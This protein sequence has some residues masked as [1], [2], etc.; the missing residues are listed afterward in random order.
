MRDQAIAYFNQNAQPDNLYRKVTEVAAREAIPSEM[1][2]T[3][4]NGTIETVNTVPDDGQSYI[5]VRNIAVGT[6]NESYFMNASKF[7]DRYTHTGKRVSIDGVA[8]FIAAPKGKVLAVQYTGPG[9][10]YPR[11]TGAVMRIA[12]GDFLCVAES[13][14]LDKIFTIDQ[15]VFAKTYALDTLFD[16]PAL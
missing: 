14:P 5:V 15:A 11:H 3:V 2:I 12:D 16:A 13:D 10:E 4:V 6:S 7:A 8:W 9:F 1:I